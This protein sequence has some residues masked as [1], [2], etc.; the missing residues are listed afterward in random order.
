VP[1]APDL[2]IRNGGI[3]GPNAARVIAVNGVQKTERQG[4]PIGRSV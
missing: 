2:A 1:I 4:T 3:A